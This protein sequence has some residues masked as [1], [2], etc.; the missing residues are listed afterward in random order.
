MKSTTFGLG[1]DKITKL[2]RMG[3]GDPGGAAK[4]SGPLGRPEL[5]ERWLKGKLP[6]HAV[7]TRVSP[8]EPSGKILPLDILVGMPIGELLGPHTSLDVLMA[9]K[10]HAKA[11]VKSSKQQEMQDVAT[12]VYY[13]AI[14][15]AW[16]EHQ[17]MISSVSVAQLC[18]AVKMLSKK[19]WITPEIKAV[20][21]QAL[22][23]CKCQE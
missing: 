20:F 18:A 1:S 22:T 23:K 6:G 14:A 21:E 7:P 11:Q 12:V 19:H 13:A 4:E 5:L 10:D 2:L 8:S 16:V 3:L 9:L 15:C 17:Q